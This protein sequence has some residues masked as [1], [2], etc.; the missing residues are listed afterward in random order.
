MSKSA[1]P[2]KP[3]YVRAATRLNPFV[4]ADS[5]LCIGCIVCE[6][7]CASAH[8]KGDELL[9]IGN[10]TSPIQPRLYL[11]RDGEMAVPVQCR[12]CEDAPCAQSCPVGAIRQVNGVILID[13]DA[14]IGCK[15]CM[16]A[17]PFGA[18]ELMPLYD[19]G[20]PVIQHL[21]LD[22]GE[23][24]QTYFASKCDRCTH[25][26]IPACIA[27]CPQKALKIFQPENHKTSRMVA[28]AKSLSQFAGNSSR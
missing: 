13:D 10:I 18:I 7:A 15:S 19:Q 5:N 6:I 2:E 20:R 1:N 24:K 8:T 12:H 4:V 25:L 23:C 21:P 17:C 14:C 9:T 16:M 27:N 11:V 28:A 26:E 22:D 3:V